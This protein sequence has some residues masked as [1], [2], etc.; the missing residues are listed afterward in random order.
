MSNAVTYGART[1]VAEQPSDDEHDD[2]END[3]GMTGP[4]AHMPLTSSFAETTRYF[5]STNEMS[6]GV[7]LVLFGS[8]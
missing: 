8:S 4:D 2:D 1:S 3:G 5:L 6:A 7:S